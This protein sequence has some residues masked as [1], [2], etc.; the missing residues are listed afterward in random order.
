[1]SVLDLA[2]SDSAKKAAVLRKNGVTE[3]EFSADQTSTVIRCFSDSF[4]SKSQLDM[5]CG[6]N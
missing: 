5:L 1:M 6:E 2:D 4:S 3:V